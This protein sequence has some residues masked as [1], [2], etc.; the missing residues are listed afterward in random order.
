MIFSVSSN[1]SVKPL[2]YFSIAW[3]WPNF[4]LVFMTYFYDPTMF[5]TRYDLLWLSWG[6]FSTKP[7][8]R[9]CN[10][11]AR[12]DCITSHQT[13][14]QPG[15]STPFWTLPR[16]LSEAGLAD[17]NQIYSVSSLI[18]FKCIYVVSI[19]STRAKI[20]CIISHLII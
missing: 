6:L 16:L 1:L 3:F 10:P 2:I 18:K 8:Q 11:K 15:S 17:F 4:L 9:R 19:A 20:V 5:Y 7:H 13:S 14:P 12:P